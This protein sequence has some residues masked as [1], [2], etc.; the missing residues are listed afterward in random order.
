MATRVSGRGLSDLNGGLGGSQCGGRSDEARFEELYAAHARR[1]RALARRRLG[2]P[3]QAEDAVQETFLHAYRGLRGLDPTRPVWPWLARIASNVCVDMLRHRQVH[4]DHT[5]LDLDDFTDIVP[6]R[7]MDPAARCIAAEDRQAIV[8]ALGSVCQRQR[9]VLMLREVEGW[10][11]DDIA[12]LEGMTLDALK[13]AL[14]RARQSF[15]EAY[16]AV[17]ETGGGLVAALS[18]RRAWRWV[19][20]RTRGVAERLQEIGGSFASWSAMPL[21]QVGG[22]LVAATVT[23]MAASAVGTVVVRP[24]ETRDVPPSRLATKGAVT[25]APDLVT[26]VAPSGRVSI[27]KAVWVDTAV[28]P[29]AELPVSASATAYRPKRPGY[30]KGVA[31]VVADVPVIRTVNQGFSYLVHCV[32][33]DMH[34]RVCNVLETVPDPQ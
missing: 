5:C 32:Y 7:G 34:Q 25:A 20:I 16:A 8:T 29:V 4:P 33:D 27:P 15:R 28:P 26:P 24:V 14:K 17:V 30:S 3:H 6:A 13:G 2:D 10:R 21:S 18:P 23:L 19:R 22:F 9:R 11:Y 12:A 1:V 31:L